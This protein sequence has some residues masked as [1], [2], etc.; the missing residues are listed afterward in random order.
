MRPRMPQVRVLAGVAL[1]ALAAAPA[2]VGACDESFDSTFAL[3]QKA[4][5]ERHGCTS[6]SCHDAAASGGLNLLPDVAYD[7]LVDA[8]VQSIAAK[9]PLVR[10]YP[11]KK[12][13]SLLWINLA[14]AT[15]P[16][17][18]KAPLRP[19][20]LGGL[21]PLTLDELEV[22]RLWIEHG[23]PRHGVVDGTGALLD[24]CLPPPQPLETAP[25][26]PPAAGTGVQFRAPRQILTAHIEREVC[27]VTYYDITD[28]VPEPFRG[29]GGDTFRYK[30]IDA[31]MDPLSHHAVVI[32]Y[33]GVAPLD[34]PVWGPFTCGGGTN[35]GQS[36]NPRDP[37]A[38]GS[39][40][41]CGSQPMPSV[42]CIGYGPGDASIGV[43]NDSLFNTM[44]AGLGDVEG[45][46]AEAPLKGMLVWNSHA[47]NVTD[48][49]GKL[50]IWV[51]LAFAA[52]E[53]QQ[54]P[55]QRFTEIFQ[56]FSL[57]VPPFGTQELCAHYEVEPN[58]RVLEISSHNHKRGKRFRIWEGK[59]GCAGGPNPGAPCS[60]FGP[61]P[62][63]PIPDPCAGTA[64]ES[65]QPPEAGDCN[66]DLA[67]T[68]DELVA[69]VNIALETQPLATCADFDADHNHKVSVDELL[70]AVH[71]LLAPMRD[72]DAS[73][74]YTSLSYSDPAVTRFDP[75]LAMGGSSAS[76]ETRTFTY[77]G[78]YDNGYATPGEVKRQSTSPRPTN[79]FP[80]GPCPV[81]I[82]CTEGRVGAQCSGADAAC[83]SSPG[84]GDGVCDACTLLF[85]TTTEDEMFILLGAF[86]T[87]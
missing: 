50:D 27:F 41:V 9:P 20:P 80:G 15:L 84:A 70:K 21:P 32:P 14:A 29:P 63:L 19:M 43:G 10:V 51:N 72:P 77:C 73:L 24:A 35:D 49:P 83:D 64:C 25:L 40:G 30:R 62:D 79:G 53:E 4:I 36:C 47:F 74:I 18:W 82:A 44:A 56:Q 75:P 16:D 57:N 8:P 45:V 34:D 60:P 2:V 5:F 23:A 46:Y 12:E 1:L 65:K 33:R 69:G 81:P 42:A 11:A 85:G 66:H 37:A 6:S 13:H 87:P 52:P 48:I 39:D 61:Q 7:N 54:H 38:C 59:F 68:V 76:A 58:A 28:Q 31:R 3:I 86:F 26:D 67:I 71:A 17:Q 55:L 22:V 78:L